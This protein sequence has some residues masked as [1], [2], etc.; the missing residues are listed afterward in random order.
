MSLA[1]RYLPQCTQ[2]FKAHLEPAYSKVPY[3]LKVWIVANYLDVVEQQRSVLYSYNLL[4]TEFGTKLVLEKYVA[5]L[6]D[7][8]ICSSNNSTV[9]VYTKGRENG[10]RFTEENAYD[11]A[12]ILVEPLDNVTDRML[13]VDAVHFKNLHTFYRQKI[14]THVDADSVQLNPF[15]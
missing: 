14:Y 3:H 8:F 13:R 5:S 1:I 11:N 2:V 9:Y 10:Q 6:Y 15:S 12:M 4:K 7:V